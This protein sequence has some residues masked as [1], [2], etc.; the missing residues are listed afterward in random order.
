MSTS[1]LPQWCYCFTRPISSETQRP[2][3]HVTLCSFPHTRD[4]TINSTLQ[5]ERQEGRTFTEVEWNDHLW[6]ANNIC[7]IQISDGSRG[8]GESK[9]VE[10]CVSSFLQSGTMRADRGRQFHGESETTN[11]TQMAELFYSHSI[12]IHPRF[13]LTGRRKWNCSFAALT[14]KISFYVQLKA[15]AGSLSVVSWC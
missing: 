15:G 2:G 13:I 7:F 4:E 12:C 6:C 14:L 11:Q 10:R 3:T 8:R 5:R 9:Q 1:Q